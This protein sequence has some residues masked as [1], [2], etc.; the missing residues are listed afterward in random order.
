[1]LHAQSPNTTICAWLRQWQDQRCKEGSL[2]RRKQTENWW[3]QRYYWKLYCLSCSMLQGEFLPKVQVLGL[4][5]KKNRWGKTRPIKAWW[6]GLLWKQK[7]WTCWLTYF[8]PLPGSIQEVHLWSAKANRLYLAQIWEKERTIW[9]F[10]LHQNWHHHHGYWK[11]YFHRK[12]VSEEIQD[13]KARNYSGS[14]Q[15]FLYRSSWYDD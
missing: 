15:I 14:F 12:L 9:C 2:R 7:T 5:G 13:G 10:D 11:R 4:D 6:Q 8:T 1:M 3:G